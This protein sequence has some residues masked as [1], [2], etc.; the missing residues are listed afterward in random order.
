MELIK[1][2][3]PASAVIQRL[4]DD[5]GLS[6][7]QATSTFRSF[8]RE[9]ERLNQ[10]EIREMRE[11]AVIRLQR[12]LMNMRA[13]KK[14]PWN[15][16]RGHESLLADLQG[17]KQMKLDVNHHGSLKEVYSALIDTMS[18]ARLESIARK[19]LEKERRL[20]LTSQTLT[21]E[22]HGESDSV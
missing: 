10:L 14:P 19:Q 22:V 15:S 9:I 6:L 2:G 3:V 11:L 21:I 12:D 8:V 7:A 5:H 16:I 13:Q 4:S 17:T 20:G 1:A 18:E